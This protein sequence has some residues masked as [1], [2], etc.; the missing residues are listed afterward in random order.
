MMEAPV[1]TTTSIILL[2]TMSTYT[3]M[4]PAALVEPAMVRMLVQS[5]SLHIMVRISAAR[6]VSRL[7]NDMLRMASMSSVES[8]FLMSMCLMVSFKRSCLVR[9]SMFSI[10]TIFNDYYSRGLEWGIFVDRKA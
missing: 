8:Y 10:V 1:E 2:R 4:Q 5:F 7:V 3:C 6:A 9:F